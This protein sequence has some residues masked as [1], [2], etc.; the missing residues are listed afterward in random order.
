MCLEHA[1][2][3][4]VWRENL[5]IH[6][7]L[8]PPGYVRL[9]TQVY[10]SLKKNFFW[11]CLWLWAPNR[12]QPMSSAVKV[13]SFNHWT[14]REF[15]YISLITTIPLIELPLRTQHQVK[16]SIASLNSSN[17][18]EV[19]ISIP[20]LRLKKSEAQRGQVTQ[21]RL[22]SY[23]Y[24]AQDSNW[25]CLPQSQPIDLRSI[26]LGYFFWIFPFY[27][28]RLGN[29]GSVLHRTPGRVCRCWLPFLIVPQEG[30]GSGFL[31]SKSHV[32]LGRA[33]PRSVS[34]SAFLV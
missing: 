5:I 9:P 28:F 16:S 14:S 10:I 7:A 30:E 12:G 26:V 34:S 11:P 4:F 13:W 18:L 32:S 15:P 21:P 1:F 2:L 31:F 27:Q 33:A 25:F 20:I 23:E 6:E 29:W 17:N 24:Q 19:E 3:L 8:I 22:P